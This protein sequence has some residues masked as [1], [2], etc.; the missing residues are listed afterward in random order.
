M[1]PVGG[2]YYPG[3]RRE[4]ILRSCAVWYR[5]FVERRCFFHL[6]GA[7]LLETTFSPLNYIM[8]L[9]LAF[10]RLVFGT[11]GHTLMTGQERSAQDW[12]PWIIGI[13]A[14]ISLTTL[15]AAP[16]CALLD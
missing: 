14:K 1:R 13:L 4:E 15:E 9:E 6:H 12:S 7:C 2:R 3:Y 11:P 5:V 16:Q 10:L 8:F